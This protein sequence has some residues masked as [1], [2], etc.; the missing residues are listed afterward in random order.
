MSLTTLFLLHTETAMGVKLNS[1][2]EGS[3]FIETLLDMVQSI[4]V[5]MTKPW[6]WNDVLY[7]LFS[8]GREDA[9]RLK[10][11]EDFVLNVIQARKAEFLQNNSSSGAKKPEVPGSR[12]R[13]LAFLDLLLEQH[14]NDP[15]QWTDADLEEEVQ[16]FFAAGHETVSVNIIWTLLMVANDGRIQGKLQ[17]EIDD[18]WAHFELSNDPDRLGLSSE[19]LQAMPYL[20]AVIKES[21]RLVPPSMTMGRYAREDV[22]LDDGLV[23]PRGSTVIMLIQRIHHDP[24]FFPQPERFIPERWT[25]PE[26]PHLANSFAYVPFSGGSRNCVGKNFALKEAKI[27]IASILRHFSL[28]A[29]QTVD[30]FT[31]DFRIVSIPKEPVYIRF[32]PRL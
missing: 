16:I 18:A 2:E 11:V 14:F 31:L 15:Q 5:R 6:F 8:T 27:S 23:I 30:K 22:H 20:E 10:K 17:Q 29:L 9:R 28:E 26:A 1:H 19:H 12:K 24:A 3:K 4:I 13:R 7:Y 21:L 32:V 25:D